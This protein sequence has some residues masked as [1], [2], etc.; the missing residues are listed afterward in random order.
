MADQESTI[1]GSELRSSSATEEEKSHDAQLEFSITA[2]KMAA[3]I[4][5]YT[6]AQGNG[7]PLSIEVM[8]KELE[9]AGYKGQLD[10]DGARF[11][12]QRANEGKSILNVALVRGVYPQEPED[13]TIIGD[14]DFRFPVLPGMIFGTLVPPVKASKGANLLGEEIPTQKTTTP[15]NITVAAGGGCSHDKEINALVSD[16]YGL[17]Q[18]IDNQIYVESL[19]HVSADSMQVRA[20]LFPRDCFGATIT[21]Q[22]I[23]PALQAI[24][25]SRPLLLVA[26]E[27]ALKTA[28]E[29]GIAQESV[30]AK[31]TEP[32]AGKNGW[33]EYEREETKS[34]GTSLDNDRIDFK[35]RGT[36]PMVNPGDIIGKIHPP[37]EGKAG[38]D[39]YGRLT[40][41]PGGQ[42]FEIK[43]GAHVAPMPDGITYKALATGMVH[44]EKGELSVIDVLVTQGDVDYSTGN[45]R[46]EKGSVHVTGSIREGFVVNVPGHILVK[47][48][49]EGAD[50]HA[51][52]DIDVSGGIIMAGKGHLKAGNNITAQFA[53]NARI[54]CGDG[55]TIAHELSNCLV[56]C[57]GA[58]T[59][60]AGKGVILGGAIAS[61]TGIE[62]NELGSDIGVQTVLSIISRP[63]V[64]KEK[65]KEREDLRDR[66]MKI[67]AAIGQD[68]DEDILAQTPSDKIQQMEKILILRAQIKRKLKE[69]RNKLSRDLADY[70]QSLERLS[71]RAKRAVHPGVQIKIGGKALTVTQPMN[72]VKFYFDSTTRTIAAVNL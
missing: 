11:A 51:G 40:P 67:N 53:A 49:I 25:I 41:P 55:L 68:S 72:R 39:V 69:V 15:E 31:G 60:T 24:G 4:S 3:F 21:L 57:K 47:E 22:R 37:V 13:G 12:L 48:S 46:L 1:R 35:E 63:P 8:E 45:I 19:I 61:A 59:A 54:D 52:G 9:K 28:R 5:S 14:A 70:Y 33:F 7:A 50:V 2:D 58:I 27:S 65:V 56:R 17:V 29:T 64:N 32:I 6:P 36:H 16:T 62:A 43:P 30:I 44:L 26:G 66:L 23:E 34:I 42:P 38:E 18:I 20:T 71:I 10:P